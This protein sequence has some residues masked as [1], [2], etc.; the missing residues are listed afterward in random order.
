MVRSLAAIYSFSHS[1]LKKTA[2]HLGLVN[3]KTMCTL[4][5]YLVNP[6]LTPVLEMCNM[7]VAIKTRHIMHRG[8]FIFCDSWTFRTTA[9]AEILKYT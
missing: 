1:E 8:G 7:A 2:T 3:I 9:L 5:T 4:L 6:S